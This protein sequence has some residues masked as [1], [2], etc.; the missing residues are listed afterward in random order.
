MYVNGFIF[1]QQLLSDLN[2]KHQNHL[3]RNHPTNL[4]YSILL[5]VENG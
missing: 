2:A 4:Q 1:E 3:V 5:F